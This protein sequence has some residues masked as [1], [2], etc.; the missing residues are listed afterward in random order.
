MDHGYKVDANKKCTAKTQKERQC[1]MPAL[2]TIDKC[3]LHAGLARANTDPHQG[4][5]KA[6][7]NYKR[8]VERQAAR[9]R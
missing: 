2:L 8:A 9:T 7:E 1:S 4:D 3:A 5:P 6:L